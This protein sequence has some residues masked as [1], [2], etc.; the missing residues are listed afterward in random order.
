MQKRIQEAVDRLKGLA[1][2]LSDDCPADV[3]CTLDLA[4]KNIHQAATMF[5][6][7]KEKAGGKKSKKGKKSEKDEKSTDLGDTEEEEAETNS[8][9]TDEKNDTEEETGKKTKKSTNSDSTD[10]DD[11]G[12]EEAD[13]ADADEKEKQKKEKSTEEETGT[14]DHLYGQFMDMDLKRAVMVTLAGKGGGDKASV[15][16]LQHFGF[17]AKAKVLLSSGESNEVRG[18]DLELLKRKKHVRWPNNK[19]GQGRLATPWGDPGEESKLALRKKEEETKAQLA[20]Q[21]KA[22]K[23]EKA[24]KENKEEED[25]KAAKKEKAG[26]EEKDSK[27]SKE[28][29]DSKESKEEKA[30]K[31]AKKGKA[32]KESKDGAKKAAKEEKASKESKEE[33]KKESELP[34]V[35]ENMLTKLAATLGADCP[36]TLSELNRVCK[37]FRPDQNADADDIALLQK[38]GL[39]HKDT[40]TA[41]A[42]NLVA[43]PNADTENLQ[44]GFDQGWLT[45]TAGEPVLAVLLVKGHFAG[46]AMLPSIPGRFEDAAWSMNSSE[47][48]T[49]ESLDGAQGIDEQAKTLFRALSGKA[50]AEVLKVPIP[51]QLGRS[52]RAVGGGLD[53]WVHTCAN[54]AYARMVLAAHASAAK[55]SSAPTKTSKTSGKIILTTLTRELKQVSP[56][57]VKKFRARGLA[58]M[59]GYIRDHRKEPGPEPEP[60]PTVPPALTTTERKLRVQ[61]KFLYAWFVC[62]DIPEGGKTPW[63]N[64]VCEGVD[65]QQAVN[66]FE[67][68]CQQFGQEGAWDGQTIYAFRLPVLKGRKD[69]QYARLE[70]GNWGD[71]DLAQL[72][73]VFLSN[74]LAQQKDARKLAG[75][76]DHDA[77]ITL[78]S[79]GNGAALPGDVVNKFAERLCRGTGVLQ[80]TTVPFSVPLPEEKYMLFLYNEGLHWNVQA[81]SSTV[82]AT[83][84]SLSLNACRPLQLRAVFP[85]LLGGAKAPK[86]QPLKASL[87]PD[88]DVC[89]FA[90]CANAKEI[91][92][93]GFPPVA[94]SKKSPPK[95]TVPE[96]RALRLNFVRDIC[97]EEW[98]TVGTPQLSAAFWNQTQGSLRPRLVVVLATQRSKETD[99]LRVDALARL[100]RNSGPTWVTTVSQQA[101]NGNGNDAEQDPLSS[102]A[103]LCWKPHL[104]MNFKTSGRITTLT[105]YLKAARTHFGRITVI[106]DW[107]WLPDNYFQ[108]SYG[109]DWFKKSGKCAQIC[110]VANECILPNVKEVETMLAEMESD[111]KGE[112]QVEKLDH[113]ENMLWVATESIK[114]QLQSTQKK[115][116]PSRLHDDGPFLLVTPVQ[117]RAL[118]VIL[119]PATLDLVRNEAFCFSTLKSGALWSTLHKHSTA[120]TDQYQLCLRTPPKSGGVNKWFHPS[121]DQRSAEQKEAGQ[122]ICAAIEASF[123][124]YFQRNRLKQLDLLHTPPTDNPLK[125][126]EQQQSWHADGPKPAR[127]VTLNVSMDFPRAPAPMTEFQHLPAFRD[128]TM[129][130]VE[131]Q[132]TACPFCKGKKNFEHCQLL[133]DTKVPKVDTSFS[134]AEPG[135]GVEFLTT[136]PHRSPLNTGPNHRYVLHATFEQRKYFGESADSTHNVVLV[137]KLCSIFHPA[138]R[139]RSRTPSRLST[140]ATSTAKRLAS[141]SGKSP[142]KSPA[143]AKSST[144]SSDKSAAKSAAKSSAKTKSAAKSSSS[145][146]RLRRGPEL[147]S[148]KSLFTPDTPNTRATTGTPNTRK[149]A[150]P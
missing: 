34:L 95:L 90:A 36:L 59:T 32:G 98:V 74:L 140:G 85:Q 33:S 91:I 146:K 94:S 89:L 131:N 55:T 40:L 142:A 108:D 136:F 119:S 117:P 68:T 149:R 27:E 12:E 26:K 70:D 137:D 105:T 17:L 103:P 143:R 21:K 37:L 111:A 128:H 83:S 96:A 66:E 50:D 84:D 129:L 64:Y 134:P 13:S 8:T 54:L 79:R 15:R 1:A 6:A 10:T 56:E 125:A 51:Q 133:V 145:V 124:S 46:L 107:W 127:A 69:V 104:E 106:L 65:R 80:K 81:V 101:A 35:M 72:Y 135:A 141:S 57:N 115:P 132:H 126:G 28:E 63:L 23:E 110:A 120:P 42:V 53:C 43:G 7:R 75:F 2:S 112:V 139:K 25:S 130:L 71:S 93:D 116:T 19:S 88:G 41:D 99:R 121:C 48:H 29:K 97:T 148:A 14:D 18:E 67:R 87:Q 102:K 4:M 144:K 31:A 147:T 138:N 30:G 78:T 16:A 5:Q 100:L 45:W 47:N 20:L 58:W 9:D 22:A 38:A 60:K 113:E 86:V 52:A 44:E 82:W 123:T 150:R 61:L 76:L 77:V 11:K 122:L 73:S 118:P 114:G 3:L 39:F 49:W 92:R 62:T 109:T 24:S